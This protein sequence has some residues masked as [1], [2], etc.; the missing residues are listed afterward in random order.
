MKFSCKTEKFKNALLRVDRITSKQTTLPI[1][2]NVLLKVEKGLIVLS[3]TNLELASSIQFSGKTQEDGQVTFPAK[4]LAGFLGSISDEMIEGEIEGNDLLVKTENHQIKIKGMD[5]GEY[6]LMPEF[7]KNVFFKIDS[8]DFIW[9]VQGILGSVANNDSRQELNGVVVK[10]KE[11][12]IIL[13]S[14]D[15]FRLTEITVPLAKKSIFK[16]YEIFQTNTKSVIIPAQVFIELQKITDEKIDFSIDQGQ[17][18]LKT[19]SIKIVSRLINGSYP[20]YRQI[21]PKEYKTKLV[22]DKNK[23]AEM[24]KI[25]SLVTDSQSGEIT[26]KGDIAKKQLIISSQSADKGSNNSVLQ[27][28]MTGVDFEIVFNFRYFLEGVTS[29]IFPGKELIIEINPEKSPV[30]IKEQD[31]K[32]QNFYIVMPIVKS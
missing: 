1:L 9:K 28:D 30:L 24:V 14:T 11:E 16:D 2:K 31:E 8:N 32:N 17:L 25:A 27:V 23:L 29:S 13:A 15:S 20:D 10:L 18:F 12:K 5:A 22:I 26:V 3:S 4:I 21:I 7:P 6:P 19:D